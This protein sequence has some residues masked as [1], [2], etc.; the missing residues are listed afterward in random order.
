MAEQGGAGVWLIRE[1]DVP[2]EELA[3]GIEIARVISAPASTSL[4]GGLLR[5]DGATFPDWTLKYDEVLYVLEGELEVESD[6][7]SA[8]AGPGEM[9]LIAGGGTVTYRS[10]A[11]TKTFVVLYPRDWADR[12]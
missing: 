4:G 2:Y 7:G 5:M 11:G 6:G 9:I 8:V 1:G 12:G 10:K 3:P